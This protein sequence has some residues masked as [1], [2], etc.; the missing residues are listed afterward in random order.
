MRN[1]TNHNRVASM[2]RIRS[3]IAVLVLMLSLQAKADGS[4]IKIEYGGTS[5]T[6][7]L[8]DKPKIVMEDGNIVLKTISTSVILSLPCKATYV[9]NAEDNPN[10]IADIRN[11]GNKPIDVFTIEGK[12]I[13]TL[14]N[15]E[16]KNLQRGIYVI[17]GKKILIK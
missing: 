13:A 3:V 10:G 11:D 2:R 1:I 8:S 6:V 15:N 5:I 14:K 4:A 17:N 9:D 12:K 7:I 16:V